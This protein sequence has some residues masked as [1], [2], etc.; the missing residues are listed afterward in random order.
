MK[1]YFSIAIFA[2]LVL[3]AISLL[4]PEKAKIIYSDD[5][6]RKTAL[7]KN[8]SSVPST[9]EALLKLVDTPQKQ[10]K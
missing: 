6:L 3:Y 4:L 5:K 8:M 2:L 9:Y 10:T 7:S 1:I